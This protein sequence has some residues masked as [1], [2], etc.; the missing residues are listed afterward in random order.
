VTG[1]AEREPGPLAGWPAPAG[2]LPLEEAAP[3]QWRL[4]LPYLR[5]PLSLNDRQH[6]QAH[7]RKVA[8][9][10][11][12]VRWLVRAAGIPP[13]RR[14]AVQLHYRPGTTRRRDVDNL[15]P[16]GKPCLDALVDEGVLEDDTPAFVD[17]LT[18]AIHPPEPPRGRMWLTIQEAR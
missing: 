13:L 6:R 5:P 11:R 16:T 18:P 2:Q 9:V 1:D 15:M 12:D 3:R 8:Q 17:V 4:D 7:A 14:A 10:R